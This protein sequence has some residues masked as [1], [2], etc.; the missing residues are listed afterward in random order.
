MTYIVTFRDTL[1][2]PWC[3]PQSAFVIPA[4][5]T[6]HCRQLASPHTAKIKI[7]FMSWNWYLFY[8]HYSQVAL[9]NL[10]NTENNV[11]LLRTLARRKAYLMPLWVYLAWLHT[12]CNIFDGDAQG[13]IALHWCKNNQIMEDSQKSHVILIA[14]SHHHVSEGVPSLSS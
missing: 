12:T 13:T 4:G 2:Q 6:K 11:S 9:L 1:R 14:T 10:E 8:A 3:T 5:S 7:T